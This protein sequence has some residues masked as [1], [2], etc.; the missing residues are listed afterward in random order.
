MKGWWP[1]ARAAPRS[2][3]VP[4]MCAMLREHLDAI[5]AELAAVG[6]KL[7]S[8]AYDRSSAGKL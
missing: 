8:A 3:P 1:Y 4:V 2:W 6:L 7:P 5:R